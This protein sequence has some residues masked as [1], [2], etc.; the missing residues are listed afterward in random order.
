MTTINRSI[1]ITSAIILILFITAIA[2]VLATDQTNEAR[3]TFFKEN[4]IEQN[5]YYY[6]NHKFE[7]SSLTRYMHAE[8][9]YLTDNPNAYV[10]LNLKWHG[11]FNNN[12]RVTVTYNKIKEILENFRN[13]TLNNTYQKQC[14]CNDIEC[15]ECQNNEEQPMTLNINVPIVGIDAGALNK[16]DAEMKTRTLN[17]FAV[18]NPDNNEWIDAVYTSINPTTTHYFQQKFTTKY[19]TKNDAAFNYYLNDTFNTDI[20][21]DYI[22]AD[23]THLADNI[24]SKI[25][26]N[27]A[28]HGYFNNNE[29]IAYSKNITQHNAEPLYHIED[30]KNNPS[31]YHGDCLIMDYV[32]APNSVYVDMDMINKLKPEIETRDLKWLSTYNPNCGWVDTL[33][34]PKYT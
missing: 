25:V 34:G 10:I 3:N 22:D 12:E 2:P 19:K 23:T 27:L 32:C 15:I 1:T 4:T 5:G 18:Y 17:W 6:L 30:L 29:K 9:R 20:L 21:F 14:P 16:L 8:E 7:E 28:G 13:K 11:W 33:W 24:G 26:L 31:Q